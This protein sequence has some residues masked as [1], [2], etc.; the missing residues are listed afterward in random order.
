L[1]AAIKKVT[2][3]VADL[4]FNTAVAEM[5]VFVNEATKATAI[6]RAWFESFVKILSPFAPH[7]CEEMWQR[8]GYQ[9][10][11]A[12]APWPAHDEAKLARA[13]IEIAVQV[14]GKV[15]GKITVD[16]EA[17][18]QVVIGAALADPNVQKFLEGKPLKM[19]KYI[20]GRLVTLAV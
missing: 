9:S 14:N 7:L 12:D 1:H 18:D 16:A 17:V 10:T 4:R 19:Q 5:M 11:I 2:Q 8:L 6:P 13:Q 3:A 15:R 20:K